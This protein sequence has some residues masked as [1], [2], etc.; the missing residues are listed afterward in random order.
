[1]GTMEVKQGC[2]LSSILSCLCF[3]QLEEFNQEP[4]GAVDENQTWAFHVI[5]FEL[6]I[7][8][9]TFSIF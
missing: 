3:D 2:H 6:F 7:Q 8:C 9:C 5:A 1:M 4:L